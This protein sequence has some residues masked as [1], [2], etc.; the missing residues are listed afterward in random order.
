MQPGTI[1]Y[2]IPAEPDKANEVLRFFATDV[3]SDGTFTLS[4]LAPGKYLALT[5]AKVDPQIATQAKLREPETEAGAARTKL[6]H[7][8]EAKKTEIELK[9]CQNVADYQLKQ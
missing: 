8:A 2:I 1:V 3:T 4:N 7:A 9:P 5:Q 6:R